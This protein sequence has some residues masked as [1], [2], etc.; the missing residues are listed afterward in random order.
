[1]PFCKIDNSEA[2][3]EE[4]IEK[5]FVPAVPCS[6]KEAIGEEELI[7]T[8]PIRLVC[9]E[10]LKLVEVALVVLMEVGLKL[11]AA[12]VVAKI[13]VEV[14]LVVVRLVMVE[15]VMVVL[16][17]VKLPLLSDLGI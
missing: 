5:G 7:P 3:V 9:P 14:A 12:K 6:A 15:V 11:V 2:P 17:K 1:M 8:L 13:L 4:F 10:T 16:L